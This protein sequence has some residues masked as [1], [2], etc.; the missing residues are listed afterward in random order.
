MKKLKIIISKCKNPFFN[1]SLEN[2]LFENAEK[3]VE[4]LYLW[5]NSKVVIIGKNQNP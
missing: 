2:T 3:N 4:T 1:I 5:Q